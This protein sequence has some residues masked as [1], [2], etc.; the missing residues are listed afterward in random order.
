MAS[1]LDAVFA[2]F[3]DDEPTDE[4]F[5]I[6]ME[7]YE[8]T[9]EEL[10]EIMSSN[11]GSD[12]GKAY[13]QRV[14]DALLRF[15]ADPSVYYSSLADNDPR[16]LELKIVG[17]VGGS[18]PASEPAAE[19]QIEAPVVVDEPKPAP[20]PATATVDPMLGGAVVASQ[21]VRTTPIRTTALPMAENPEADPVQPQ[22][23]NM[24]R[25]REDRHQRDG[26]RG[27][28]QLGDRQRG[29]HRLTPTQLV[30]FFD[31]PDAYIARMTEES[32]ERSGLTELIAAIKAKKAAKNLG[33]NP[34]TNDMKECAKTTQWQGIYEGLLYAYL[35][36]DDGR[37]S[38]AKN[39]RDCYLRGTH[40]ASKRVLGALMRQCIK[41]IENKLNSTNSDEFTKR[42][43][44]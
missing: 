19:P 40:G 3:G 43:V 27:D 13:C 7:R 22:G 16:K 32:I 12:N 17:L 42:Y 38:T 23:D 36:E 6:I 24:R 10:E 39:L 8:P 29:H 30:D 25:E 35:R 41:D 4:L 33:A 15:C 1:Y 2:F 28:G 11:D 37:I 14:S 26:Q 9:D 18:V 31:D 21:P 44:G 34:I 5:N 20:A